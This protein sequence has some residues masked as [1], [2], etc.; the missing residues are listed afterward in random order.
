LRLCRPVPVVPSSFHGLFSSPGV[1]AWDKNDSQN[2][3]IAQNNQ[4]N[5]PP[6]AEFL[7]GVSFRDKND[8]QIIPKYFE[9][10]LNGHL[11][12]I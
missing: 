6:M 7:R 12:K 4:K 10:F 1:N 5:P 2:P 11:T 3:T 8:S 9:Q